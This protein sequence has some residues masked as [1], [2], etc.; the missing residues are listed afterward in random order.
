MSE[1]TPASTAPVDV[2][3]PRFAAWITTAVLI[4]ALLATAA[5]PTAAAIPTG[6]QAVVFGLT[7]ALGPRRGPYGR[8][9]ATFVAPRLSPPTQT[10]PTAPLRFAQLIGLICTIVAFGGFVG[11][12]V[13][14][15]VVFV[16]LALFAAFLNAA[17]GL[18][19]GCKLY[20]LLLH[21]QS[22]NADGRR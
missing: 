7:A 17:F 8:L 15:G 13:V 22:D 3:G 21:L 1:N 18:C 20:P 6:I 9:Y 19:L 5:G 16:A 11:G 12:V 10:E 2:R 4:I 14:L